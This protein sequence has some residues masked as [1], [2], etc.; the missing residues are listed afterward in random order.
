MSA[1]VNIINIMRKKKTLLPVLTRMKVIE[2]AT[3][4][5]ILLI[6]R[7]VAQLLWTKDF[8]SLPW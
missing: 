2:R 3:M 8:D 6:R 4:S 1:Q 5:F 7:V